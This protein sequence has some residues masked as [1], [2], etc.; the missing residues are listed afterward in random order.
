MTWTNA[1]D[2]G[3]CT[4]EVTANPGS[5]QEFL[6]YSGV[7]AKGAGADFND[8]G[9]GDHLPLRV[10]VTSEGSVVLSSDHDISS[11][12]FSDVA[13]RVI[14]SDAPGDQAMRI[15]GIVLSEAGGSQAFVF[16]DYAAYS[17]GGEDVEIVL[18]RDGV[19]A[20]PDPTL[21]ESLTPRS[22]FGLS[23]GAPV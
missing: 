6:L 22:E 23:F 21:F 14:P 13:L 20:T 5:G 3:A 9:G 2:V 4:V 17:A 15:S 8:P 7:L 11:F 1:F 12:S 18:T 10:D 19:A 16:A